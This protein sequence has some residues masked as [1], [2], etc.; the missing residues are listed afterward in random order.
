MGPKHRKRPNKTY[1]LLAAALI[2]AL[3]VLF[4]AGWA[5]L[6]PTVIVLPFNGSREVDPNQGVKIL[7]VPGTR[8]E[9]LEARVDERPAE[10]R[11]DQ[12]RILFYGRDE[13]ETDARYEINLSLKS[14][15]GRKTYRQISFATV[16]T[17]KPLLN[18]KETLV[19][20]GERISIR[21]NIP[22]RGFRYTLPSGLESRMTLDRSGRI[23]LI[24]I[25]NYRQGQQFDLKITDAIG[26]NGQRMRESNPGYVQRARTT[27]PLAIDIDPAY[28]MRGQSR[29]REITIT[30]S[31]NIINHQVTEGSLSIEP[32]IPGTL[33][34]SQPNQL[35]F[36]PIQSWD[37]ET[38]AH[39][40]LKRG[41]SGAQGANGGYVEEDFESFFVVIPYKLIDVNLS[42]QIL[43]AFEAGEPV[44]SCL[45]SSGKPGYDTPAGE[46]GIYAKQRFADMANTPDMR[47][48]YLVKDVPFV[49]WVRRSVAIHGVYWHSNFG[50]VMSH[51]CIGV[52]VG[53]AEW[54]YNWAPVGTPVVVHY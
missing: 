17:P 43:V 34:W 40:K 32:P 30:F 23:G 38:E 24:R 15:T 35:K 52:S 49:N 3:A 41:P 37:Y 29:S 5:L 39:I 4:A 22:V 28:G 9:K 27:S 45:V 31:E 44:F 11:T 2:S 18:G 54:I 25:L 6:N 20:Y 46:F 7:P 16:T 50:H 13:L 33:N 26:I 21:W 53:N 12:G 42:T 1:F 47:E 14:L 48:T 19:R 36:T 8:I 10:V 51:G